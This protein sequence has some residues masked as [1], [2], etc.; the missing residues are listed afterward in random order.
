MRSKAQKGTGNPKCVR[1]AFDGVER[2]HRSLAPGGP[3]DPL[4]LDAGGL[5]DPVEADPVAVREREDRG[6]V[7]AL[8]GVQEGL[9]SQQVERDPGWRGR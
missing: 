8:G 3:V 1:D 6:K 7:A 5:T 2:G 4:C 9:V